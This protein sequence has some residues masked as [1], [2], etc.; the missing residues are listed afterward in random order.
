MKKNEKLDLFLETAIRQVKIQFDNFIELKNRAGI[1]LGFSIVLLGFIISN[2]TIIITV[3]SSFFN[4]IPL[5]LI[6]LSIMIFMNILIVQHFNISPNP[7]HIYTVLKDKE[8]TQIK[9]KILEC[10]ND[11]YIKN[12]DDIQKI[13]NQINWGILLEFIAIG[14]IIFLL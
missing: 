5:I 1:F 10:V 8:P 3:K 2:E 13:G 4:A 6:L 11:D 7:K 14:W 9:E 12:R